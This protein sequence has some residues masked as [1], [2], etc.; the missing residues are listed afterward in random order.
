MNIKKEK[1]KE[2]KKKEKKK[3]I[4]RGYLVDYDSYDRIKLIFLDN[5]D[6]SIIDNLNEKDIKFT[7][8]YITHKNKYYKNKN[9]N[10]YCPIIDKKYFYIKCKKNQKC[11]IEINRVQLHEDE[12]RIIKLI[13]ENEETINFCGVQ[14][15]KKNK[16]IKIDINQAIQNYVECVVEINEYSFEFK[17]NLK[18]GYNFKLK[19]IMVI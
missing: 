17:G 7:K 9:P 16:F 2:K 13:N 12:L 1:K 6:I 11:E 14:N 3:L 10:S 8:E 18:E 5:S 4:L 19:K 15:N